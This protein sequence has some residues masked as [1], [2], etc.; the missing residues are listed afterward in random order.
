[1][2]QLAP[3]IGAGGGGL[4]PLVAWQR[5]AVVPL[6]FA[7]NRLWF[8]GQL[9]GPSPVYNM[10]VALQLRGR[11]D[12]RALGAALV[13]VVDRHESL[14]TIFPTYRWSAVP[15]RCVTPER[16]DLG[17]EVVDATRLAAGSAERGD[18]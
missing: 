12:A 8:L 4:D 10:A 7:Q 17:W 11:L 9:Q 13:D 1:M 5:P 2:A 14:R 16:A 15:G 3:R 18:R 6:S